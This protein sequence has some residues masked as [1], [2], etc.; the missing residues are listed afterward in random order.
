MT[1]IEKAATGYG[2]LA[3]QF[4]DPASQME[5]SFPQIVATNHHRINSRT[6]EHL[7]AP[8]WHPPGVEKLNNS[9]EGDAISA[10][11]QTKMIG[12]SWKSLPVNVCSYFWDHLI[13]KEGEAF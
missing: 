3:V 2:R 6:K 11:I 9:S 4:I 13:D 8:W 1:P 10:S 7:N 12:P 5:M